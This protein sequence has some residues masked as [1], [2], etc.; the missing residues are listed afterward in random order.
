MNLSGV[1][2][3]V[4]LG[5]LD[6]NLGDVHRVLQIA[7]TRTSQTFQPRLSAEAVYRGAVVLACAAWEAFVEDLA[8]ELLRL[9]VVRYR[10]GGSFT[11]IGQDVAARATQRVER[12][13]LDLGDPRT[14]LDRR[15]FLLGSFNTPKSTHINSLFVRIIDLENFS[16]SW[17]MKG[18]SAVSAAR[19]LDAFVSLRG[20]IAHRTKDLR[21]IHKVDVLH[22]IALIDRLA[23][24]SCNR[25]RAW[26]KDA[27]G[28]TPGWDPI[29]LSPG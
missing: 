5:T 9:L 6:R 27:T 12:T 11:A 16:S 15:D 22:G 29:P 4:C 25:A 14:V 24:L 23:I 13:D 8:L 10:A 1:C 7:P 26:F 21:A 2:F 3:P 17:T 18:Q 19:Q 20:D 28:D